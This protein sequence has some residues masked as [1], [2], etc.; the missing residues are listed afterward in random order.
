MLSTPRSGASS[1]NSSRASSVRPA[2]SRPG[3]AHAPRPRA[4][5]GPAG[6]AGPPGPGPRA[7]SSA[8]ARSSIARQR[9]R[10]ACACAASSRPSIAAISACGPRSAVAPFA[11]PGAVAQHRDAVRHRIDLVQEVRDEDDR[12]P[13]AAQPAQHRRTASAPRRRPGWRSARRGSAPW[14]R[15]PARARSPPSAAPRPDSWTAGASTS[16]SSADARQQLARAPVHRRPVDAIALRQ[17]AAR[18][19][20]GEDVLGHREVGAQ[21]HFLVDRAD[22]QLLRRQRRRRPDRLCRPAASARR[23]VR[24][25]RSAP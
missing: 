16:M 6:A 10:G 11:D 12:Q 25:R 23:W 8:G 14:P 13:F 4:R 19:A 2:P 15:C 17:A 24:S 5:A 3:Q 20:A 18:I 1:P 21:V 7:S 9:R 22:A